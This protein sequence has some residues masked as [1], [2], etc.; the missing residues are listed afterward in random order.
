MPAQAK[1]PRAQIYWY[2]AMVTGGLAF[3]LIGERRPLGDDI[4]AH[5]LILFFM[6]AIAGLLITRAVLARPVPEVVP[7]RVLLL[8]C[9]AGLAAFL[10]SNWIAA[11]ILGG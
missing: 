7:E 11:H 3:G 2:A 1:L 8:G 9:F 4:F 10:A 5:P 6:I